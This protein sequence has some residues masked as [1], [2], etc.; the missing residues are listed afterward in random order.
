MKQKQIKPCSLFFHKEHCFLTASPDGLIG[1][2]GIAEVSSDSE[3]VKRPF[4]KKN[5]VYYT[6]QWQ[7]TINEKP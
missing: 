4:N 1:D 3:N 2:V 5:T 7:I 6:K